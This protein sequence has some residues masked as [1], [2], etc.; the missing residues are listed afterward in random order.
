MRKANNKKWN[1]ANPRGTDTNEAYKKA[2][3]AE[4]F[5]RYER[6]EAAHKNML[7]NSPLYIGAVIIANVMGLPTGR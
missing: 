3:P 5:G 6:A 2:V 4:V 7:E 1:N